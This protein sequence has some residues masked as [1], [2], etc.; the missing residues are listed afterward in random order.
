MTAQEARDKLAEEWRAA[1]PQTPDD[2]ANFYRYSIH[3]ARDLEAF[4]TDPQRQMWTNSL[5]QVAAQIECNVYVDVGSGL[6]HDLRAIK[7]T[8]HHVR[9]CGVEPCYDLASRYS[10]DFEVY[11]DAAFA[12]IEEADLISCFDVLEHVPDPETWL[13]AIISR[14]KI[15]AWLL[16]TCATFDRGTPLHLKSHVGWHP[17]RVLEQHGFVCTATNGRLRMWRRDSLTRVPQHTLLMCVFRD[18]AKETF[19]SVVNMCRVQ[20][21]M[22]WR[23]IMGGEAGINRARSVAVSRWYRET[24]DD[25]FL[26]VDDDIVWTPEDATRIV[27]LCREGH[28]IIAGAYPVR[29]GSHLAIRSIEADLTLGAGQEPVEAQW[30]STGFF[31]VHRRVV[32]EMIKTLPL[33]HVDK[34]SAFWPMFDFAVVDDEMT[35]GPI[36]LSE[37]WYFCNRARELGFKSWIDTRPILGHMA[38]LKVSAMNMGVLQKAFGVG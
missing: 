17:G 9:A 35:G 12:P 23:V 24:A 30:V 31:A 11:A 28:D 25:V 36:Y 1:D 10:D 18:V 7:D 14:A 33:C 20:P 22:Y 4:H 5:C 2:I 16:E 27:K 15:G 8:V 19:M 37:D 29:S 34:E 38:Q 6:G 32:A 26:M 13:A 3:Q 21:N